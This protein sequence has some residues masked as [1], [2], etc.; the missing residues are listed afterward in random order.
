[1]VVKILVL[2]REEG[3]DH[4]PRDGLERHEDS[5]LRCVFAEETAVARVHPS[6]RGRL[7]GGELLVVRQIATVL[8][9]QVQGTAGPQ[10]GQEQQ[11]PDRGSD[12]LKHS[13]C[14]YER[15]GANR[16]RNLVR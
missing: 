6:H 8:V 13:S 10:H 11:H 5:L 12:D 9:K 2:G 4:P 7:V 14:P 1:M 16:Y 3:V 15:L